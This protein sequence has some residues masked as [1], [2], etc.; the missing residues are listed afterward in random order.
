MRGKGEK[1][2]GTRLGRVGAP[3]ACGPGSGR[4]GSHR[5]SK[6]HDTHNH[7]SKSNREMKT[8]M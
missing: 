8:E 4:A 5:G 3:G 1:G 2:G 7:C 6:A